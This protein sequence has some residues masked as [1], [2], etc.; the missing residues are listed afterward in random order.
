MNSQPIRAKN[1]ATAFAVARRVE[2]V[3]R[4][5]IDQMKNPGDLHIEMALRVKRYAESFHLNVN[6]FCYDDDDK[7]ELPLH[8]M[9]SHTDE[10]PRLV[11]ILERYNKSVRAN[12]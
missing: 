1:I 10:I 2:R 5:V 11:E 4:P 9:I 12:A 7:L 3:L 8:E 6:V